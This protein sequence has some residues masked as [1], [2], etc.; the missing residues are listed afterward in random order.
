V[1]DSEHTQRMIKLYLADTRA[2]SESLLNN[3][4][5]DIALFDAPGL[6]RGSLKTTAVF[7]RQEEIDVVVFVVSSENPFHQRS[8]S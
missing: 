4:G 8:S 6:N 1:A 3:G 2:P 7:A 5:V